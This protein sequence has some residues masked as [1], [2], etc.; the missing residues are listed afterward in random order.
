M[1]WWQSHTERVGCMFFQSLS[2]LHVFFNFSH[3][4]GRVCAPHM[5]FCLSSRQAVS[6]LS[7]SLLLLHNTR[8]MSARNPWLQ[9]TRFWDRKSIW[10]SIH[11]LTE[12]ESSQ[13]V[14]WWRTQRKGDPSNLMF[15]Q[16][17]YVGCLDES[18]KNDPRNWE[19]GDSELQFLP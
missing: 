18:L 14:C 3:N 4:P 7:W 13:V 2:G 16:T 15:S 5:H 1:Y 19:I 10:R 11:W 17:F 8:A 6:L 12:T 9:P